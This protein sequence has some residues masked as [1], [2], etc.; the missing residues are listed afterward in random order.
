MQITF[1]KSPSLSSGVLTLVVD[2]ADYSDV[3]KKTLAD[4]RR[5]ANIPGF[6]PGMA[7]MG[8]IKRQMGAQAKVDAVNR[9]VGE[10]LY[11]YIKDNNIN[12]LGEPMPN[13]DQEPVDLD[14]EAPY[15]M[16]FDIAV[17]PEFKAELTKDDKLVHYNVA[18]DDATIDK[19][20]ESFA[21]RCGTYNKV[22][23]YQ[24]GDMLKGDL[25]ELA[26]DGSTLEGGHT[27]SEAVMMPQ[28]M[29]VE[30]Q[31]AL[32][33]NLKP[34]DIV[35]FNPRKAYP[36]DNA[37]LSSLL[38]VSKEE[39]KDITADF[40]YQITEITRYAPHAVDQELFDQIY[41]PGAVKTED[42]FRAKVAEGLAAQLATSADYRFFNDAHDYVMA[43]IGDVQYDDELMKR[44]ML[45]NAKDKDQKY[46]DDNY[47]ASIKAL[48][49]QLAKDQLLEQCKVKIDDADVKAAAVAGIRQQFAQY[50]MANVP[51]EMIANYAE[52]QLKKPEQ[53][54]RFVSI[55][56]DEKL[57]QALKDIVT[58][59]QKDITFEEFE[60]L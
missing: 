18:V 14:K 35:T 11:A 47:A 9:V 6:R 40:S 21:S 5:R 12:M 55:A 27:V 50:G 51:D 54:D 16:K 23:D 13:K 32:F 22:D 17:A 46:V 28:Y 20:V 36:D 52:E 30:E 34:G 60:K 25:R 45:A 39:A 56:A 26:D 29:K 10:K 1:E 19:Q 38:K 48:T 2:D 33:A 57:M 8:L 53:A 43:K 44:I 49:W 15:T 41:G 58:L 7:P 3:V 42:E 4:A 24:D 59:E 31:K 37:E